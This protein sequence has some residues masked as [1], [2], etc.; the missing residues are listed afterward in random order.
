MKK[1][2]LYILHIAFIATLIF[3][4]P[5]FAG[6]LESTQ[7]VTGTKNLLRDVAAV[8]TGLVALATAAISIKNVV[9]WQTAADEEKPK[10]KKAFTQTLELG[11]LGT[12]IGGVITAI[13][14]YYGG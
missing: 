6:S 10:H 1:R 14:S 8:L 7:L 5:A 13:L 4:F 12:C 2:T 11:I 3:T 9:T